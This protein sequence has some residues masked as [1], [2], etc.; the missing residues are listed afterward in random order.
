MNSVQRQHLRQR[1]EGGGDDE[2]RDDLSARRGVENHEDD[3]PHH[4]EDDDPWH[5]GEARHAQGGD[6]A[7]GGEP[8]VQL[9]VRGRDE[10]PDDEEA[11]T[12]RI[13][14][15]GEQPR[16]VPILQ[17]HG[18]EREDHR[19][20]H[21]VD[22]GAGGGLLEE[23]RVG[24]AGLRHVV[25]QAGRGVDL[26]VEGR[27]Q[28]DGDSEL[29]EADGARD[30]CA[31][32]D[33]RERGLRGDVG[34]LDLVEGQQER[35]DGHGADVEDEDAN[36]GGAHGGGDVA[37]G[38]LGLRAGDGH[39]L[40]AAEREGHREETRG[41]TGR[42]ARGEVV[43]EVGQLD[44]CRIG[45]QSQHHEDAQGDKGQDHGHLDQGEP[46]L[47]LAEPADGREVDH[48]EEDDGDE[49]RNPGFNPEP[50]ADNRGRAGDLGAHDHDE[51]EPVEP[52]QRETRPVA[53]SVAGIRG[54]GAEGRAGGG[55]L[56][57]HGHDEGDEN[58]RDGIG[59]EDR[60]AGGL[61]ADA[62]AQKEA[63]AHGG[64]EAHHGEVARLQLGLALGLC[65]K[66]R[67]K[68]AHNASSG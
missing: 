6:V 32:E 1:D 16:R 37:G 35:D 45:P 59:N 27:Q 26:R 56:A 2:H 7:R 63:S 68:V 3:K 57:E 36:D 29:H 21:R 55:H 54:E 52:A 62:D 61:D 40:D 5:D 11:A 67:G 48:S 44:R 64:A 66:A 19:K 38:V 24:V 51:H 33:E 41:K 30:S 39:Q 20:E 58:A 50:V 8:R 43:R 18:G 22:G 25:N 10:Q 46:E 49:R 12:H 65:V 15:E 31:L 34:V 9:E 14:E 23:R 47:E 17:A 4:R 60:G 42:A 13:E 28:R 53:K